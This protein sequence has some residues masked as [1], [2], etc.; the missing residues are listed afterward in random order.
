MDEMNTL[1]QICGHEFRYH[2]Q[3]D[4]THLWWCEFSL[5]CLCDNFIPSKIINKSDNVLKVPYSKTNFELN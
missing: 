3:G 2:Q 1:C 4:L 5:D